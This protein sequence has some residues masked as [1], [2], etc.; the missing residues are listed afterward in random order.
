MPIVLRCWAARIS[1]S[2]YHCAQSFAD[3]FLGSLVPNSPQ[4]ASISERTALGSTVV[5]YCSQVSSASSPPGKAGP[6][7]RTGPPPAYDP[8]P[9][10]WLKYCAHAAFGDPYRCL[11]YAIMYCSCRYGSL[12]LWPP[13]VAQVLSRNWPIP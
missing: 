13:T 9:P 8:W 6:A 5:E 11:M 1:S 7:E 12:V 10:G 3:V 4:K 2:A